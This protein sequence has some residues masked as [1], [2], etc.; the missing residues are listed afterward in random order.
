MLCFLLHSLIHLFVWSYDTDLDAS[1]IFSSIFLVKRM[2][3]FTPYWQMT[4]A[5]CHH[6][7]NLP[8]TTSFDRVVTFLFFL[9]LT[10]CQHVHC[11]SQYNQN[12]RATRSSKNCEHSQS[13][14]HRT[15]R[16]QILSETNVQ[17]QPF[18]YYCARTSTAGQT[19]TP[20]C[21]GLLNVILTHISKTA[22]E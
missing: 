4:T 17:M 13:T 5:N 9:S 2:N 19:T 12:T 11:P 7:F 14:L 15:I 3:L 18:V 21:T 10:L 22:S 6:L 8:N 20:C 1:P 16:T